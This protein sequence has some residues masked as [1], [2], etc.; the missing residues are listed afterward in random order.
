MF[1]NKKKRPK[2]FVLYT[3]MKKRIQSLVLL[4][5]SVLLFG[6]CVDQDDF[7]FDRLSETS[8]NP[9]IETNLLSVSFT[10]DDL[11]SGITDSA[12]SV[13]LVSIND[14]LHL[15]AFKDF[16]ILPDEEYFN[17]GISV[18]PIDFEF[19][20]IT[21]P[22]LPIEQ[23]FDNDLEIIS[24]TSVEMKIDDL[25]KYDESEMTRSLDSII[26]SLGNLTISGSANLPYDVEID[27]YSNY[28][29]NSTT[30]E[31]F[32]KLLTITKQNSIN[33]TVDL[34]NYKMKFQHNSDNTSSLVFN[35]SIKALT[36][37]QSIQG[38][39]YDI[40]LQIGGENFMIEVAWG[41]IGNP[42]VP[43]NGSTEISFF[44]STI[45]SNMF[46]FQ[47]A[48]LQL[49]VNNYTGLDLSLDLNELKTKTYQGIVNKMF[50]DDKR[51]LIKKSNI[52]GLSEQSIHN[53]SIN[54]TALSSLPDSIIY[55]FTT[56]FS[57]DE[58]KGWIYPAKK[59]VDIH[60]MVDV[61][62]TLKVHEFSLEEETDALTALQDEDGVGQ[63]LDS[64]VLKISF[65]NSFPTEL[66]IQILAKDE[67]GFT[68]P[69]LN[70]NLVIESAT[71]NTDGKVLASKKGIK[72]VTIS[73]ENY[74]KLRDAD[75]LIFKVTLNT[76]SINDQ[77]P[78]VVFT[79]SDKLKLGLGI[80]AHTKITF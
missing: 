6:A 34:T 42:V 75:K 24:D 20:T 55:S 69:L 4:L 46:E 67:N 33:Q 64:A 29:I 74:Q 44:D 37:D 27:L 76:G 39:D 31:K 13:Y 16:E 17:K 77:Q 48:D 1:L 22:D 11:F 43:L 80:K 8:I 60:S 47:K 68:S 63:Y 61:P 14:T 65:D 21:I 32:H 9:A 7:N 72:E 26:L 40:D 36:K 54:P 70:T 19:E 73:A 78:Y 15:Q 10:A 57:S 52:P 28:L 79:Q 66:L 56:L 35:Y 18:Q 12:N 25:S 3:N 5:T 59:Y 2:K 51:I 53:L 49:I 50:L 38:G 71:L 41:E 58:Q 30:G 62:F 23:T 45:T